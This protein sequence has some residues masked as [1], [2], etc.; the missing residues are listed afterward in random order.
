MSETVNFSVR[1][2]KDI[3]TRSEV[4]FSELG[5]TLTS[6]INIFLRKSIQEGGIP[7]D[8]RISDVNRETLLAMAEADNISK[9][10]DT[11]QYG[12]IE[13]ALAELKR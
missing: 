12:N 4:I 9:D 2:N 8:L 6:A 11:K 10:N 7:F 1:I 5:L 3:K 13:E